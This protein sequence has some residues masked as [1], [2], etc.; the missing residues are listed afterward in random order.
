MECNFLSAN[1][2]S[3]RRFR[4]QRDTNLILKMLFQTLIL[5]NYVKYGLAIDT[6]NR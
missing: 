4:H 3:Y 6:Y 2:I 5:I 1:A